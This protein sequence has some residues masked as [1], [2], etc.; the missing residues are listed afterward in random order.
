L[1]LNDQIGKGHSPQIIAQKGWLDNSK[2]ASTCRCCQVGRDVQ[3]AAVN[4]LRWVVGA[5]VGSRVQ[6]C[7][8]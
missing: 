2:G 3:D 4:R 1:A 8:E 7:P 6:D 5:G